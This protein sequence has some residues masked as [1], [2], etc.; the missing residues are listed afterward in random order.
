MKR[1]IWS[2]DFDWMCKANFSSILGYIWPGEISCDKKKPKKK[3]EKN[4]LIDWLG[5]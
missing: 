2:I 5:I 4:Y 3:D 1:T